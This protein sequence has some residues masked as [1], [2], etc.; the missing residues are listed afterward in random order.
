MLQ[1]ST[2][3]VWNNVEEELTGMKGTKT[4]WF[5]P[6]HP[7]YPCENGIIRHCPMKHLATG[8]FNHELTPQRENL[9]H[10]SAPYPLI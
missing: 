10:H 7:L 1:E 5:Y 2:E 8:Y 6:V 9:S 3:Y 4:E